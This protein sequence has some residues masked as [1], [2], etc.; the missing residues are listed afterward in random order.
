MCQ[1]FPGTP[2]VRTPLFYC[3]GP[4]FNTWLRKQAVSWPKRKNKQTNIKIH[5]YL[6]IKRVG[7]SESI[8]WSFNAQSLYVVQEKN[9]I[10]TDFEEVKMHTVIPIIIRKRTEIFHHSH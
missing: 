7:Q 4:E 9:K 10:L 8:K 3:Y 2:V 5:G 6:P 1:E